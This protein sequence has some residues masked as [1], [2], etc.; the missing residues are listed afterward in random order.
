MMAMV[1]TPLL[2]YNYGTS[3]RTVT[4]DDGTPQRLRVVIVCFLVILLNGGRVSC[5]Q[6]ALSVFGGS[7]LPAAV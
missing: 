7:S 6:P 3:C 5:Q 2:C 1:I 4:V